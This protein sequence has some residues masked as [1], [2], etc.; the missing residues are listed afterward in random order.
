MPV[1]SRGRAKRARGRAKVRSVGRNDR[2]QLGINPNLPKDG[3]VFQGDEVTTA[4]E[5]TAGQVHCASQPVGKRQFQSL[6]VQDANFGYRGT[7]FHA[8]PHHCSGSIFR[9]RLPPFPILPCFEQFSS[10]E[11]GPFR[12]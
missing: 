9:C 5:N 8:T 6:I 7:R 10:M 11:P 2:A 3:R 12:Y 4:A 1:P